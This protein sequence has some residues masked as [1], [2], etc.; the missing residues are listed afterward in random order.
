MTINE[1]IEE[2][3]ELQQRYA[4]AISTIAALKRENKKLQKQNNILYRAMEIALQISSKEK[5]DVQLKTI[6]EKFRE[7]L[8]AK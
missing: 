7:K 3:R 2:N 1:I 5:Q 4:K 8:G 6:L